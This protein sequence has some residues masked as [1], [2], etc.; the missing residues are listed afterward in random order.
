[1][2]DAPVGLPERHAVDT[3]ARRLRGE[4]GLGRRVGAA[5]LGPVRLEHD[6][7]REEVAP[8]APHALAAKRVGR[9]GRRRC[10]AVAPPRPGAVPAAGRAVGGAGAACALL[11]NA[12]IP[13]ST[14][15][16]NPSRNVRIAA[17]VA[18]S[19]V[20]RTSLARIEPETSTRSTTARV[21]GA[22]APRPAP[23]RAP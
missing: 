1:E 13:P 4:R 6:R 22:A 8:R 10:Q 16:G 23:P 2:G 7:G 12:P 20:G 11:L 14:P 19:R 21:V 5:V 9:Q 3:D 18:S 15:F 17:T